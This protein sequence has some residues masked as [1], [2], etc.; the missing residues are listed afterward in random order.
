M[1]GATGVNGVTGVQGQTGTNG[2]TG[3]QGQTGIQGIAGIFGQTGVAGVTGLVGQTGTQGFQGATGVQ[4][5][6]GV[7]GQT[8]VQGQTGTQGVQGATGIQ[9]AAGIQGVQGLTG[10]QGQ[11]GV[12]GVTGVNGVTGLQGYTGIKGDLGATG[13]NG[14]TGVQGLLGGQGV[15]GV[16]YVGTDGVTGVRGV[17]GL[18]GL[19]G[20]NGATGANGLNG[21][22][23]LQG[24]TGLAGAQG[25]TGLAGTNGGVGANGATGVQGLTGVQG[26]TGARGVDGQTG[27]Q[28]FTGAGPQGV[29]GPSGALGV[30]PAESTGVLTWTSPN[31]QRASNTTVNIGAGTG[32]IVAQDGT[33]T[34]VSWSASNGLTDSFVGS[35]GN[36]YFMVD[37]SGAL[38]QHL[39]Y[40]DPAMTRSMI[41]LGFSVHSTVNVI[42]SCTPEPY[43]A[44]NEMSQVRDML[45]GGIHI[46][47]KGVQV[48]NAGSLLTINSSSG[49]LW[50]LGLGFTGSIGTDPSRVPVS[51]QAPTTFQYRTQ[52]GV[53]SSNTT[54]VDV[55][56]YDNG[57]AITAL[58]G[59]PAKYATH[60]FWAFPSGLIRA[61][62]PQVFYNSQAAA[63][64]GLSNET[65]VTYAPFST[66]G[67]YIGSITVGSNYT[68]LNSAVF[69]K[70]SIFGEQVVN[71]SGSAT[72]TL[73]QAY[74]NSPTPEISTTAAGGALS[75]KVGTGVD[76]DHAFETVNTAG[77]IQGYL[78]GDGS[79]HFS[80]LG[81]TGAFLDSSGATGTA[82]QIL[83]KLATGGQS[84][85]SGVAG[86]TGFQ[87]ITG[88]AG[89]TG[90]PG[91]GATGLQG[92]TGTAG[93]NGATGL[94]GGNGAQGATGS[95]TQ[96]STGLPGY[97]GLAGAQG[98]TGPQGNVG[99]QG[100]TGLAG[101]NGATGVQGTTGLAG[102]T[103][104]AGTLGQTGPQGFT[105]A[106]GVTGLSGIGSQG[107]TGLSG[108]GTQG[109]TGAQGLGVTGPQG[110][111]G[112]QGPAGSGGSSAPTTRTGSAITGST[113]TYIRY[114]GTGGN[115]ETFP[116]QTGSGRQIV[117]KHAGSGTW[118]IA[119]TFEG[120]ITSVDLLP[121]DSYLLIDGSA[122][123]WEIN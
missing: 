97:T 117:V 122:S 89:P 24:L 67:I 75:V 43:L 46:I 104:T 72:T 90:A 6:T 82:N 36:T 35:I 105:G 53:A 114:T 98:T 113:E 49:Y 101:T 83:V 119:G 116:T 118:S 80:Y 121:V 54:S 61:Q 2:V 50:G 23:G 123:A 41:L 120:G 51:S 37:S 16:G 44:F 60:R 38:Q 62:H 55:G 100:V 48:S 42:S 58:P 69:G 93:V 19:T 106:P 102:S 81:V 30:F 22:T 73:Q 47:N 99:V 18:Q 4:G 26:Y 10:V 87:G 17:T 52:T 108:I 25:A 39:N 3:V 14:A 1:N 112:P 9:G 84:W 74:D 91:A 86:I 109:V 45:I 56:N 28:G 27:L 34:L 7:Y 12:S 32:Q 76:S 5:I 103:G 33:K 96:G 63:L 40:P 71:A 85:S 31:V 20:V 15:T 8:G 66:N 64:A 110:S 107:V 21:A 59:G 68:N 79:A 95:G 88:L 11:T 13:V 111:T 70:A 115:T 92:V 29:T 65:F 77:T 94:Q 57:G 78:S